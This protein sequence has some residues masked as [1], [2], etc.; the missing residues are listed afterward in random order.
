MGAKSI[1]LYRLCVSFIWCS[2]VPYIL[3]YWAV[4]TMHLPFT[5]ELN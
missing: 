5:Q 2:G 3:F 4:R 1:W